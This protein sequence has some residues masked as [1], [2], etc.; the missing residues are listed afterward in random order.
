MLVTLTAVQVGG[1]FVSGVALS[2]MWFPRTFDAMAEVGGR[3]IG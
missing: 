2:A 3:T 1:F